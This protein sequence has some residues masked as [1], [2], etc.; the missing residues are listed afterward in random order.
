[1]QLL[2]N[3]WTGFLNTVINERGNQRLRDAELRDMPSKECARLKRWEIL[4][5]GDL[6]EQYGV[7]GVVA[8]L[9]QP[10]PRPMP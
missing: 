2:T 6:L 1:M 9:A 5:R 10:L 3:I 7:E 8:N 4:R